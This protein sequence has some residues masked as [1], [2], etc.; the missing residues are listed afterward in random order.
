MGKWVILTS[1]NESFPM[2]ATFSSLMG[3][4]EPFESFPHLAI[5]VSGGADSMALAMLSHAWATA[6]GG[7]V[8]ALV[9]DHQLRAESGQEA[10][11]VL[12]WLTRLGISAELLVWLGP[13]PTTRIQE[14]ARQARYKLLEDWCTTH[15]I[16]HLLTAHHEGDQWE[17]MMQRITR[18]SGVAGLCGIR[19][20]TFRSF[21]RLLRPLLDV[22]KIDLIHYLEQE[23]QEYSQDPSNENLKFERVRWRQQ[24]EQLERSGYS[25]HEV[26][27][28][29]QEACERFFELESTVLQ[30]TMGNLRISEFGYVSLNKKEWYSL[31]LD[32]QQYLMKK[33]LRLMAPFGKESAYPIPSTVLDR[34]IELF[35]EGCSIKK[36]AITIGGCYVIQKGDQILVTRESRDLKPVLITESSCH[37]DR[38]LIKIADDRFDG[39]MIEPLGLKRAIQW[40]GEGR[41]GD[42]LSKLPSYIL[43]TLPCLVIKDQVFLLHYLPEDM[44]QAISVKLAFRGALFT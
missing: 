20:Q 34:V 41:M 24:R 39:L 28:I 27:R 23:G 2:Q 8:T 3:P 38:F 11:Q 1:F 12:K 5:A 16:L 13:K 30:W 9:V 36:K 22:T 35:K 40:M 14:R 25:A 21:G 32:Q 44:R 10:A 6:R 7:R 29:R 42:V 15:G 31:Q 33:I 37:W 43:A 18:G 4:F 26:A 17:T 19:A